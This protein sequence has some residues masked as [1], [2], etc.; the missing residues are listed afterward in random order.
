M[1]DIFYFLCYPKGDKTK[2]Q[3]I[4]LSYACS[5]ERDEW[6]NVNDM[7]FYT[8]DEAISYARELASRH[9][10]EYVSFDSRYD[11]STSENDYIY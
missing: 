9:N 6:S 8:A 7:T 3:V 10:K 2:I 11:E 4:D 5:Y 1:D